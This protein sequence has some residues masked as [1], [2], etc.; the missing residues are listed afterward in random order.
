[1]TDENQERKTAEDDIR[2]S[3]CHIIYVPA[4]PSGRP[5]GFTI[6][7]FELHAH[8]E[9]IV[10]GLEQQLTGQ[11]L[12]VISHNLATGQRYAPDVSYDDIL[13]E[14]TCRFARVDP[15]YVNDYLGYAVWYYQ[16]RRFATLQC[17][18]PDKRG[19]FPN[20]PG[21][22]DSLWQRQFLLSVPGI[23]PPIG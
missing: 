16:H 11:I 10:T 4:D 13:D 3:G 14:C 6:G 12:N 18:W 9:V 20:E 7:L 17:L 23:H 19:K 5:F 21:Y 2:E 8:P 15:S 1:M 22:D